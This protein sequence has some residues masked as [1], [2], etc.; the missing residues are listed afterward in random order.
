MA[1]FGCTDNHA[2]VGIRT[3]GRREAFG[4]T[5]YVQTH[6]HIFIHIYM[7]V[8]LCVCL[9]VFSFYCSSLRLSFTSDS[10]YIRMLR[11]EKKRKK[12]K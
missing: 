11:K 1:G 3:S 6:T 5:V 10:A 2:F 9:F 12:E 4:H 7:Y 8:C